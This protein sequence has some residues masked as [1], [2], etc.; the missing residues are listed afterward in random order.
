[1]SNNSSS[2]DHSSK[3]Y[4]KLITYSDGGARGNPGPAGAGGVVQTPNGEILAEVSEYLGVTTNNIAEYKALILTL[5]KASRFGSKSLEVRADSELMVKQLKGEYKVKNEGLKPLYAEAKE[6][7]ARYK[8]V[9]VKH[10]YRSDN[11]Q[12]DELANE[13]MDRQESS[14]SHDNGREAGEHNAKTGD[15]GGANGNPA[16]NSSE[17]IGF[18]EQGT[19]F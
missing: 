8:N 5:Q 1:M 18:H 12:A 13:A 7:L 11:K 9:T 19:L 15:N 3:M 2:K 17:E 10:V 6:L 4:D 14:I 16:G